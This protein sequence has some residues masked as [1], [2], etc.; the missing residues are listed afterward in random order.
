MANRTGIPPAGNVLVA[1]VEIVETHRK[2]SRR[3]TDNVLMIATIYAEPVGM[4]R[5]RTYN[6]I[7]Y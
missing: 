6:S 7:H 2:H 5:G 3:N 4:D 1:C